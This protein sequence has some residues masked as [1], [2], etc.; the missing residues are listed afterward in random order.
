M[1]H[2]WLTMVASAASAESQRSCVGNVKSN[3]LQMKQLVVQACGASFQ[4]CC[5]EVKGSL[6]PSLHQFASCMAIVPQTQ[7]RNDTSLA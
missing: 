2:P 1:S 4:V 6:M 3:P 7:L 5:H